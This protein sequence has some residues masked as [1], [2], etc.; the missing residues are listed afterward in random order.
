MAAYIIYVV[1]IIGV[2]TSL[3]DTYYQLK[4][5]HKPAWLFQAAMIVPAVLL[6][7]VWIEISDDNIQF[8]AFLTCGSLMFVGAS[9]LFKSEFEGT[10]HYVATTISLISS[11]SWLI[12]FNDLWIP[13]I[14]WFITALM[15][16]NKQ[17][18]LFWIETAMIV[19][20]Y[21]GLFLC[22]I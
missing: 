12:C 6:M 9:P 15:L 20:I 19:S 14:F 3:S 13:A 10:I 4:N 8:L 11:L 18:L 5:I 17:S 2:P 16:A 1:R 21:F 22:F 7:P